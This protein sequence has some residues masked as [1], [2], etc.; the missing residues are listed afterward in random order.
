MKVDGRAPLGQ[1]LSDHPLGRL[2]PGGQPGVSDEPNLPERKYRV[3]CIRTDGTRFVM[4][5]GLPRE[6]AQQL[7][8]KLLEAN[9]F[10]EVAVEPEH[11]E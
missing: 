10:P 2:Q 7:R 11:R 5:Y 4:A 9:I 6:D 1:E 8:D 3:F